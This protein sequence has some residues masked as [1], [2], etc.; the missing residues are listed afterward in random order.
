MFND[1]LLAAV[2]AGGL[3]YVY[4]AAA[5]ASVPSSGKAIRIPLDGRTFRTAAFYQAAPAL[6]ATAFLRARVR[7][8]GQGPLLGG[9]AAMF[10]DGEF[11]GQ[12][13]IQTT[14]PGGDI[15]F[16]LGADQDI[17]LVRQVVPHTQTTGIIRKTDQTDYDVE[18]Q[19]GNYK[20]QPIAIDVTDQIPRSAQEKVE[21]NLIATPP[22]PQAPPPPHA[23]P[24]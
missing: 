3:D 8:D 2:I 10:P 23:S 12:G 22:A 5:P 24:R 6:A 17:R 1:P 20:K 14:G 13:E 11:V 9:S 18:I 16:P 4:Q 7:N 15:E 21:V 19:I